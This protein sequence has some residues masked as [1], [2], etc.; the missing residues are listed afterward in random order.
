[1]VNMFVFYFSVYVSHSPAVPL[2]PAIESLYLADSAATAKVV[3]SAY[4]VEPL[5]SVKSTLKVYL[6]CDVI[7]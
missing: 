6:A 7:E 1:M 2:Y 4:A 3:Y 5:K